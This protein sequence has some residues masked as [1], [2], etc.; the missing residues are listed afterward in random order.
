MYFVLLDYS[1]CKYNLHKMEA[2]SC[3]VGTLAG[4]FVLSGT[5]FDPSDAPASWE[6]SATVGSWMVESRLK[7][8]SYGQSDDHVDRNFVI[9]QGLRFKVNEPYKMLPLLKL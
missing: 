1:F 3:L 6:I 9:G 5:I 7:P 2:Q 8:S 4:T